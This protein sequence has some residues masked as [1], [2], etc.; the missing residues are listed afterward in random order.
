[1]ARNRYIRYIRRAVSYHLIRF[2]IWVFRILPRNVALWIG[3]VIGSILPVLTRKNFHRAA[4]HLSIAF[5]ETKTGKEIRTMVRSMFRC[6]AMNFIDTVRVGNMTPS[7]L[8]EVCVP[9][10][11]ERLKKV[12]EEGHGAI[13]LTSHTGCWELLG[14]YLVSVGIPVSAVAKRLYDERLEKLLLE[15]R[16]KSGIEN[17]TSGRD[18]REVVRALKRGRLLG[19]LIDQDY[20]DVKGVFVDFFGKPAN[21]A[22]GPSV[23]SLR[24]GAPIVPVLTYRDR[25]HRHH[26]CI[27][28]PVTIEPSGDRETDIRRLT[29]ASLASIEEFIREHPEQWV[30]F[31]ERWRTSP[32]PVRHAGVRA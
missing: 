18:T 20:M 17:I 4:T 7:E 31:H 30:W 8:R 11:L 3:V 2:C 12:L 25:D 13:G 19:I 9:H 6:L 14:A 5:G 23:L 15:S 1:M 24:Y 10:H 28:E 16:E 26:I 21:T 22:V 32:E 29:A 27:G